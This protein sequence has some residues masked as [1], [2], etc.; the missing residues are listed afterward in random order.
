[1]IKNNKKI[2]KTL[3]F[4]L[5]L[6][7]LTLTANH[8]NAQ[9]DGSRGLFGLG[10]SSADYDYNYN[11]RD[12]LMNA[13]IN[14]N[15]GGGIQ[16]DDFGAPLGSG[17]AIL[18]AAGA[19]YAVIRRKRSRKGTTLLLAFVM[20]LGFTECKKEQPLEPDAQGEKVNITLNV[21]G[22][23]GNGSRADVNPPHVIFVEGDRILVAYDGKYVGHID[24][25]GTYFTGTI[26]AT[27]NNTKPLYFYFLGNKADVSGLTEGSSTTCTVNISDQTY[28][29][30]NPTLP[31]ISFSASDQNFN[32]AGSYTARLHNKC[33]LM[34][35]NVT[36]S[37]TAPICITGMNNKVTVDFSKIAETGTGLGESDTDNGFKYDKEGEGIL[38]MVGGSS[39]ERWLIVLPQDA[40][41][42]T[43]EAFSEDNAYFGT[44]PI[45]SAITTDQ[46]LS[47]GVS[48]T[49]NTPAWD[50]D[51]S[52]LTAS[53][54]ERYATANNGVTISG[55]L[56]AD[57][58]VSIADGATVTLDG[59]N[60][61]NN[62][63]SGSSNFAGITCLGNATLNLEGGSI[64][65]INSSS[66]GYPGIQ[67]GPSGNTLTIEGTGSLSAQG[68]SNAPGIGGGNGITC[69]NISLLGGTISA[70]GGDNAPGLGCGQNGSCGNINISR[71]VEK[72]NITGGSGAST[73]IGTSDGSSLTIDDVADPSYINTESFV[74][75]PV[76]LSTLTSNYIAK[77]GD[78]LRGT[79]ANN[80][81]ISVND[82][83]PATITLSG[84]NIGYEGIV[85]TSSNISIVF[86]QTNSVIANS[87]AGI[88]APASGSISF[89]GTGDLTVRSNAEGCAGIGGDINTNC[90]NIFLYGGTINACGGNGAAGIGSGQGGSCG[91]IEI[92]GGNISATGGDG[93]AGIGSGWCGSC[94]SIEIEGGAVTANG[95]GGASNIGAGQ[96]GTCGNVTLPPLSGLFSVSETKQVRFSRGNLQ[97]IG[98][99]E[100][101]YWKFAENQRDYIGNSQGSSSTD[102]DRDLF[103]WGTSGYNGMN[104]YM[105]DGGFNSYCS[106]IDNI[107]N[108][109]Y[110]W[111]VNNTISNATGQWRT[112]TIDEWNYLLE[113]HTNGSSVVD[114]VTGLVIRPDGVNTDVSSSYTEEG[115]ATEEANGAVFLPA[116]GRRQRTSVEFVGR[117]LYYW[118]SSGI[119]GNS[120]IAYCFTDSDDYI[121]NRYCGLSVRLVQDAN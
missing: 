3:V 114:G 10:K 69:G 52:K 73:S 40:L 23:N 6:A 88:R 87:N 26:D 27:G 107:T 77:C 66:A 51:L 13:N 70:C 34:K 120:R 19:G 42:G 53:S 91:N 80:V 79:L 71:N 58:K 14:S 111:G 28:Q 93:A 62:S 57:V 112:L 16:N 44:R 18:L 109:N 38:K 43:G 103:G 100:T 117:K 83:V 97:Y 108:T 68:G 85:C 60:I 81:T 98:S 4:S 64:N 54:S 5:G 36:T 61:N 45:L 75:H 90:G 105:T 33:S 59:A 119:S 55:T 78:V 76:D 48:M 94:G 35:F 32:G 15:T 115:W 101:P 89:A 72:I 49:V 56:A 110:D 31:V 2:L 65:N 30:Q 116:A 22:G 20:L 84:A 82:N 99:A 95:G 12:G 25:N 1:M 9:N 11:N 96:N 29:T 8:L 47:S 7:F 67:A 121:P 24:Y 113:N 102:I 39:A 86:F 37:S 17:I 92:E 104:P 21:N 118:S 50:G 46:Y 74:Y 63:K 41:E 106:G